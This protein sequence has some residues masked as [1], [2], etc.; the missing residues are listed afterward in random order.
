[1]QDDNYKFLPVMRLIELLATLPADSRVMPNAVGN[2]LVLKSDGTSPIAYID[3]I[4][5][6]EVI[7]MK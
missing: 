5:G 2:L 7:P 1:M 3:F 6:G 4:L